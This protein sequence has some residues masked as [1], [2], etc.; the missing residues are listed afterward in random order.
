MRY[1]SCKYKQLDLVTVAIVS[2]DGA[3]VACN[4]V[5]AVLLARRYGWS[6]NLPFMGRGA[7][8]VTP[9]VGVVWIVALGV[10]SAWDRRLI[11]SGTEYYVRVFRATFYAY[12]TVG[13]IGFAGNVSATRPFV[14][15]AL[16][17]GLIALAVERWLIRFWYRRSAVFRKVGILA[18]K[19]EHVFNQLCRDQ[20]LKIVLAG[21]I[22][23]RE[24]FRIAEEV[25]KMSLDVLI[26]GAD[27]GL[28]DQ[29]LREV[30]WNLSE[31]EVEVWFD[32]LIPFIRT[33]RSLAIPTAT[34]TIFVINPLHLSSGQKILKRAFDIV[35]GL[36]ATTILAPVLV[37]ALCGVYLADGRPLFYQQLRVGQSGKKFNLWKIR[38]M[39]ED[40]LAVDIYRSS[41]N[42]KD[43]LDPRITRCGRILRRWSI[44]EIPQL[45]N[46]L[47]GSMSLVGPRPRLIHEISSHPGSDRR[48]QA[49]PGLTGPW[50]T[51]GRAEIPLDEAESIDLAY[52]D[53]WTL[54]GDLVL[55]IRTVKAVLSRRGAY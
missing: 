55:L 1:K 31:H 5:I 6:L 2:I 16:P 49:K 21:S 22:T 14:V 15:F 50:Q 53:G 42:R 9:T 24:P 3:M 37:V 36:V 13:L 52:V 47:G 18:R 54:L 51:S 44:D 26:V 19:P 34:T 40:D 27:H 20:T 29:K 17:I 46:V 33:G 4:C 38:T 45:I 8:I 48:L 35:G 7:L 12:G 23:A 11:H 41:H 39:R 30:I 43:P 28:E 32:S 10:N 25:H